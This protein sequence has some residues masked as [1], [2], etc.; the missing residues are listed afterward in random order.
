MRPI[1]QFIYNLLYAAF[2]RSTRK[3]Y[4]IEYYLAAMMQAR[5]LNITNE[6]N[7]LK[8]YKQERTNI[9]TI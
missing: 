3:N 8:N 6:L 4:E 5:T 9:L 7:F 2:T 1:L